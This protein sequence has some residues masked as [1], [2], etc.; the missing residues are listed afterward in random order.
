MRE[1]TSTCEKEEFKKR[2]KNMQHACCPL[3]LSRRGG[4]KTLRTHCVSAMARG[5][6]EV[7]SSGTD[8]LV[9]NEP[10]KHV[11][12]SKVVYNRTQSTP[13]GQ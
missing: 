6:K 2:A 7:F 5:R 1:A 4:I 8:S 12:D 3:G 13:V 11:L 10:P 9:E